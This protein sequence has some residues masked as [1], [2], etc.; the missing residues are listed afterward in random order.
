[1]IDQFRTQ[2]KRDFSN[3]GFILC[4]RLSF[5]SDPGRLRVTPVREVF[6]CAFGSLCPL[7][8]YFVS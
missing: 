8:N 5:G 3:K 1:V 4:R 7:I 2:G 6:M